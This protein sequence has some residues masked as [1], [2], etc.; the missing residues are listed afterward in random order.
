[1][2][3]SP[4][5]DA[6]RR[7]LAAAADAAG[8]DVRGAAE[9]LIFALDPAVRLVLLDALGVA[10]AEIG[11]QLTDAA[12]EL[13][14]RGR[15]PEFV[16]L[17]TEVPEP[18]EPRTSPAPPAPPALGEPAE[19]EGTARL[20]LRL[21]ETVKA[22]VEAVAAAGGLSVNAWLVRAVGGAL[23]RPAPPRGPVPRS[24]RR[25]SGWAH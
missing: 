20:T 15:D 17:H 4:Y 25:I 16:V 3:L 13:R 7:D 9:R 8:E 21:P 12:V 11:T 14:L 18:P 6:L 19:D 5:T 10:A 22:R 2:D 1:M 23:D 24:G